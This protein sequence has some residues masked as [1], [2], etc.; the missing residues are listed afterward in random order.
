M[1]QIPNG[2]IGYGLLRY[3]TS[4]LGNIKYPEIVFNFLG[5]Q[6]TSGN[7]VE[8]ISKNTRHPLSERHYYLEINALIKDGVLSLNWSYSNKI[9]KK[10]TIET[11][12]YN[13]NESLKNI[14]THCINSETIKYTPSDFEEVD[15]D[16]D[17]LDNL[18]NDL[19]K[20]T[21]L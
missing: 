4:Y 17:D 13:F 18:M 14:V 21:D 2:G 7:S 15:L 20:T 8:Y 19:D 3:Y 16:Q 12:I 9:H 6:T 11:L 1:R 5:K 10:E